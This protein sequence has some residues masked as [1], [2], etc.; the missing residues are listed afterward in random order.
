[1]TKKRSS[2]IVL[3]L[4]TVAL[5][6][7]GAVFARPTTS[8]LADELASFKMISGAFIR[9]GEPSQEDASVQTNFGLR[10]SAEVDAIEYETLRS[11]N[12]TVTAGTFIL[13]YDYIT[14]YSVLTKET[15]F[16][17]A[18]Q[19]Y[20][21]DGKVALDGTT[22]GAVKI[23]HIPSNPTKVESI[24]DS[25]KEVYRINGSVVSI[26]NQNLDLNYIGISYIKVVAND[27]TVDY[28]FAEV[29][30]SNSRSP[31]LVAQNALK[32]G[33][34]TEKAIAVANEYLSTYLSV[35]DGSVSQTVNYNIYE[36][37]STGGFDK[38]SE[39]ATDLVF[40]S[41]EDF[42][43]AK[44]VVS[45]RENSVLIK[46]KSDA[47]TVVPEIGKDYNLN[48]YYEKT[49]GNAVIFDSSKATD[50]ASLYSANGATNNSAAHS[51]PSNAWGYSGTSSI[52]F[53]DFA[54]G[55]NAGI[56]FDS[57]LTLPAATDTF[58]MV[59]KNSNV[60]SY[61][62]KTST[63]NGMVLYNGTETLY[64]AFMLKA[65]VGEVYKVTI[66]LNAPTSTVKNFIFQAN[67]KK[68][69]ALTL[70]EWSHGQY[71]GTYEP[72][73]N[74][75]V[76]EYNPVYIDFIQA[77]YPLIANDTSLTSVTLTQQDITAG[78]KE[79]TLPTY[80]STVYSDAELSNGATVTYKQL[81][82]GTAT[83]LT[84]VNGKVSIPVEESC[85]YQLDYNFN[86]GGTTKTA[87][88]YVHGYYPYMVDTFE[89]SS[90]SYNST[91]WEITQTGL[92]GG[93]ALVSKSKADYW[94]PFAYSNSAFNTD[95]GLSTVAFWTY[96]PNSSDVTISTESGIN[97]WMQIK[98]TSSSNAVIVTE[99]ITLVPG[100]SYHEVSIANSGTVTGCVQ[101]SIYCKS[102]NP[103]NVR[104]D[105]IA[106]K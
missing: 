66:K 26:K 42:V 43:N 9:E 5:M 76:G 35:N 54:D 80:Q 29:V 55:V 39:C 90:V 21:W 40:D 58:T 4:L 49:I 99:S 22:D 25:S 17:G 60:A 32:S 57:V 44:P 14:N 28:L 62:Q 100:W 38:V 11:N 46:S 50:G 63:P 27:D 71:A 97:G 96:N 20:T 93:K 48:Y 91:Y 34:A 70:A 79:I 84:V 101:F 47:T 67:H 23:L 95:V 69:T 104:F 7:V 52:L 12:K 68:T 2:L 75:F 53:D 24:L 10:F 13:P 102:M 64:G 61:Q 85:T 19:N 87:S 36:S 8:A 88:I 106:F 89:S 3:S 65:G 51:S 103:W 31:I 6:F 59:V 81:P 18:T 92:D 1:M 56:I 83:P 105:N 73:N 15:C 72:T 41:V 94:A 74:G 37:N 16:T 30:E 86:L 77:E 33:T 82:S 45:E 98:S 78:V